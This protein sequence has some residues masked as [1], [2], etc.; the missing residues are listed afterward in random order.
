MVMGMDKTLLIKIEGSASTQ[1]GVASGRGSSGGTSSPSGDSAKKDKEEE[2]KNKDKSLKKLI[3][4]DISLAAMLKQSQIF[5]GF[6]GSVFQLIGMLVDVVLAPL[7]PY[8]F[9]LVGIIS[10]WIPK[11]GSWS[12]TAVQWLKDAVYKLTDLVNFGKPNDFG[13]PELVE[14]GFRIMSISGLGAMVGSEFALKFKGLGWNPMNWKF[15]DLFEPIEQS[16][17][18]DDVKAAFKT[19]NKGIGAAKAF[20]SGLT[21]GLSF[22]FLAKI[23]KIAAAG[24]KGLGT[25]AMIVGIPLAIAEVWAAFK[26]GDTGKAITKLIMNMMAFAVPIIIGI[27]A[28]GV[29]PGL[30]AAI[31]IGAGMILWELLVP[32]DVKQ[33][34]YDFVGKLFSEIGDVFREMFSLGG[35]SLFSKIINAIILLFMGPINLFRISLSMILTEGIKRTIND[36]VRNLA[37]GLVNT[38]IKGINGL[39]NWVYDLIPTQIDLPFGKQIDLPQFDRFQIAEQ[40]FSSFNLM[41]GVDSLGSRS[42]SMD[43]AMAG[44]LANY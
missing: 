3:G 16:D 4:I 1:M 8:L 40:S 26:E 29:V 5:T 15:A 12:E 10:G 13:V 39:L 32:E 30:V 25:M 7:A 34:V 37:E 28:T 9:K 2:K 20:F 41:M 6:L 18:V 27:L 14:Q 35:G 24:I 43:M 42:S 19:G 33:S 44:N 36:G 31:V 38:I 23:G 17:V 22:A 11:I 21:K